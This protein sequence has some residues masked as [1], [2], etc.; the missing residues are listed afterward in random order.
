MAPTLTS[1]LLSGLV[2]NIHQLDRPAIPG[3]PTSFKVDEDLWG[4][5][6]T[7]PKLDVPSPSH[8]DGV[9]SKIRASKG[10]ALENEPHCQGES[11]QDQPPS[12]PDPEQIAEIIISEKDESDIT[13]GEPQG[14]STPRSGLARSR[15]QHLE[16]RSPHP[17]T[18]K[19]WAT[20]G[21]EKS[22]PRREAALPTGAKEK[23]LLP[24]RYDTF[25]VDN[26]WVHQ[27]RC[28]LLGLETGTTPSRED[29][30]TSKRFV[31]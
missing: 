14:S 17:S 12:E 11:H 5:G 16:D 30:D 8:D 10:E 6:R 28:S 23:D 9:A 13:I 22:M 29:I 31:P 21:E 24:K 4:T 1:P 26:N 25:T 3:E 19:K 7:P 20:R 2:G 15:K 27:V 18:P